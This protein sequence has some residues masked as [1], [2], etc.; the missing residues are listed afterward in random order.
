MKKFCLL[1]LLMLPALLLGGCGA[2]APAEEEI[3]STLYVKA[4]ELPEDFILGMDVSS[5]IAEE[6]SGVKFYDFKGEERDLLEL[7]AENGLTH[8]R[9]RIWNDPYDAAG[10]G[11]GGGNNDVEKA[12]ELGRRAT[13]AGLRLIVDFH[14]SD[15]WADPGKQQ[16]P[17]AW[18]DMDVE[19]KAQALHDY[20]V[21]CLR[22]LRDAKVD[23]AMVQ[24]GNETNGALCG[25]TRWSD[26]Q[27][28]MKAGSAAVRETCPEALVALHFAN[29]EN[30]DAM[31]NYASKLAYYDIDYDVF[32]SSYYPFWHGTR[33]NLASVLNTVAETYG[34]RTI[35]MET[36]YAYTG[37]DTDFSG[38]SVSDESAGITKDWPFTVQGQANAVRGVIETAAGVESCLGVVYWEGAWISVG[39]EDWESNH[40][41]WEQYGSGWAS[42]YAAVYDPKDAGKYYGGSSWDNQAFF[43]PQGRPLESLRLFRLLR[44]GNTPEIVA[45]A[46]QDTVL[47]VDLTERLVLP[48]TV[49]AVMSDGS[50]QPVP[51]VWDVTD[52]QIAAMQNGG[53][54]SYVLTGTAEGMPARC[55]LTMAALNYLEN[56]GFESGALAPWKLTERGHAD[57]L[58]V[59]EKLSDSLE[60]SWHMHFWS[61]KKDS[62]DF[63]LEQSLSDLKPGA[64]RYVISI[65]GGDCAATEIFA[66]AQIDGET[67]ATAP[68]QIT[69]YGSWDTAEFRNIELDEGQTLTVGISVKCEGEKNGAWGK[70]DAA[71]LTR[72]G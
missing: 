17:R 6:Q 44:K 71:E 67:A 66:Y 15:F 23:V 72:E 54:A 8:I 38:N 52:E 60:G 61:A 1:L 63:S 25:E 37:A 35:V 57:Q 3:D 22:Q 34:K 58:Y 53:P 70:I 10:N 68:M 32:A 62:V 4:V 26:I 36:S 47:R 9:V 13:A 14:Y 7:L 39:T 2:A 41:L 27:Q 24:I 55:A 50:L 20:T 21:D 5:L 69:S 43:D 64:Y 45:D 30:S 46:I 18:A 19:T 49:N 11:F 51:V 12:V 28:L 31:L 65:M 56:P 42:S 40:A 33:E 59:E 16:A 48:E 29:P